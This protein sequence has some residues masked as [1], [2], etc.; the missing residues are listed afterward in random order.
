MRA[1]QSKLR[2][3][4]DASVLILTVV[5]VGL[6]IMSCRAV[7]TPE[8]PDPAPEV[9]ESLRVPKGHKPVAHLFATG[10]QIYTVQKSGTP[11]MPKYE[12]AQAPS[13]ELFS[14]EG[15][16]KK[17]V[18]THSAGPTW[19]TDSGSKV[20]GDRSRVVQ[21]KVDSAIPWLLLPA[22]STSGSGLFDQV[23]YIQRINTV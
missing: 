19:V 13:A 5:P 2:R 8:V 6:L 12:W 14:N 1:L 11:E 23:S 16:K 17:K 18:G 9:P 7:P 21:V 22:S 15:G 4:F 10:V 3:G 20:V